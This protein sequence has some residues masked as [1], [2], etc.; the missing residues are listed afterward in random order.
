MALGTLASRATGFVRTAVIASAIGATIGDAYNLANT[1][2]N[3]VYELLLGGVLTS[4]VV[5]LLVEGSRREGRDKDAY[6][7]R[8]LTLVTIT[9]AIAS[10]AAILLAPWIVRLY[11]LFGTH[12][13]PKSEIALATLF[14]RFFLPQIFFYGVGAIMGAILNTRSSYAAPMWSPVLNN[15]VVI[16]TGVIFLVVTHG[17]PQAGALT[18]LQWLVLSIG[19]TLGIVAQTVALVPA[20]RATGFRLVPR[21]GWHGAGVA[22]A[23]KLAGWVFLYVL[24]NQI[25]YMVIVNLASTVQ[26][27]ISSYTYA[28]VLFSLPHAI[29]GV[30]VITALLPRMSRNA[31]DGRLGVVSDDLARGLKL[32]GAI[33]VPAELLMIALGPFVATVVFAHFNLTLSSAR[34]VGYVLM[35]FSTCLVP[36]SIFQLQLR[37]FYALRDTRTPAL[38]NVGVNTV[39]LAVDLVFF[40]TL[41]GRARIVGLTIGYACSYVFG[42]AVSTKLLHKKIGAAGNPFV[43]RTYARLT[44]AAIPA[45]VVAWAIAWGVTKLVGDS[46]LP[47]LAALLVAGLVAMAMFLRAAAKMRIRE[48]RTLGTSLLSRVSTR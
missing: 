30:S 10:L 19:T 9:L 45:A 16:A 17:L 39:N 24:A 47:T 42:A 20:L 14:A 35:G 11:S 22:K 32:A 1:L 12:G 28:F 34:F 38:I 18:R 33:L 5:P 44:I 7:Q 40:A 2:P 27:G 26:F 48:I 21:F 46:W 3:I 15:L 31:L 36:F 43:A 6:A 13:L 23:A 29:V 4:V 8:M 41:H 25:T 37:A